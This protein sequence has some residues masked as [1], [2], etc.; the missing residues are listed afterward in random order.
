MPHNFHDIKR[1][2]LHDLMHVDYALDAMSVYDA[3][4]VAQ[5]KEQSELYRWITEDAMTASIARYNSLRITAYL[6]DAWDWIV[7]RYAEDDRFDWASMSFDSDF[8]S[9]VLDKM[10]DNGPAHKWL[11]HGENPMLTNRARA[12]AE[13]YAQQYIDNEADIQNYIDLDYLD[14]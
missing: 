9:Y 10:Q 8:V 3:V 4:M 1:T 13:E 5:D 11:I 2:L 14:V 7:K 6:L 12:I